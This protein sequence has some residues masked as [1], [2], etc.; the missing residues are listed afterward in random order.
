V[1]HADAV[2][3]LYNELLVDEVYNEQSRWDAALPPESEY[4][5][6]DDDKFHYEQ[7]IGEFDVLLIDWDQQDLYYY[8]VKT[9][10]A[11]EAKGQRQI[12]RAAEYFDELGYQLDGEVVTYP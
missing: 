6:V 9:G 1:D 11:S 12:D 4:F 5:A 2:D 8:E 3:E 10:N 7:P